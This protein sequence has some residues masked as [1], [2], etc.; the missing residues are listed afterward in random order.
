MSW[1]R[2]AKSIR[3]DRTYR[4]PSVD[5]GAAEEAR[6]DTVE[7]G[8][9][10]IRAPLVWSTFNDR[11]EGIVVAH[12]DTGVQYDHPA[13]VRQYRGNLGGGSFDHNYNWFDPSNICG[14]PSLIPCDN[15]AHGTHTIRQVARLIV[16]R[17][18]TAFLGREARASTTVSTGRRSART[19]LP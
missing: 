3:A 15:N 11:G 9:D 16:L 1:F 4:L 18:R 10:R 7:W 14:N 13:L 19:A 17:L 8:I 6:V 5:V 12:I 2:S